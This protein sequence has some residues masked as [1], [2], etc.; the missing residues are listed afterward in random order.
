MTSPQALV[1]RVALSL[2]RL[3]PRRECSNLKQRTSS[4]AKQLQSAVKHWHRLDISLTATYSALPQCSKEQLT[5]RAMAC[6]S[7][8]VK[9]EIMLTSSVGRH[10]KHRSVT[11]CCLGSAFGL[12]SAIKKCLQCDRIQSDS[13]ACWYNLAKP[14]VYLTISMYP[15]GSRLLAFHRPQCSTDEGMLIL[16]MRR[17]QD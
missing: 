2:C 15:I 9:Q 12:P 7:N 13:W 8:Q 4:Y 6:Q 17:S 10:N 11:D 14:F 16:H 1:L 3:Q 5:V